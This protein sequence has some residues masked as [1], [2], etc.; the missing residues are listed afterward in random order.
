MGNLI[1]RP[2]RSLG[3]P[4]DD[5]QWENKFFI[6]S[7]SGT[8]LY[9]ISQNKKHRH[10]GCNCPGYKRHR[11][12]KHLIAIGLPTNEIPYEAKLEG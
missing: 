10:W 11:K 3:F 7:E 6:K 2:D 8:N 5:P 12:C 1:L 9:T 4:P